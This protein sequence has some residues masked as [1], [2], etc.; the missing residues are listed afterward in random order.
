AA[1]P[2]ALGVEKQSALTTELVD[3]RSPGLPV[4]YCQWIIVLLLAIVILG[5]RQPEAADRFVV[6]F[7]EPFRQVGSKVL[8]PAPLFPESVAWIVQAI[9]S[10]LCW[11]EHHVVDGVFQYSRAGDGGQVKVAPA[12]EL[13]QRS[14]VLSAEEARQQLVI[15]KVFPQHIEAAGAVTGKP[16]QCSQHAEHAPPGAFIQ[17]PRIVS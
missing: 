10:A 17:L 14:E 8:V 16:G 11:A 12:G 7:A 15:T 3:E 6:E 2:A 1:Q 9:L 5:V 13:Q 4:F